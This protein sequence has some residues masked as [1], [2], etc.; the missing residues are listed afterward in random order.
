MRHTGATP[1]IQPERPSV[2]DMVDE[3]QLNQSCGTD[4]LLMF[5]AVDILQKR[6]GVT[7]KSIRI[8]R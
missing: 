1:A 6:P 5:L 3:V 8:S 7:I 2:T 4:P